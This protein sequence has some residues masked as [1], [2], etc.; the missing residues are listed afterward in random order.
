MCA[1]I[2]A[3]GSPSWLPYCPQGPKGTAFRSKTASS[4]RKDTGFSMCLITVCFQPL[5]NWTDFVSFTPPTP[6][7]SISSCLSVHLLSLHV[8]RWSCGWSDRLIKSSA[9]SSSSS[10]SQGRCSWVSCSP[11]WYCF[12]SFLNHFAAFQRPWHSLGWH[13]NYYLSRSIMKV[14]TSSRWPVT[15]STRLCLTIQ[16]GPSM[17]VYPIFYVFL[18]WSLQYLIC[19]TLCPLVGFQRLVW[20]R[21]LWIQLL[22]MFINMVENG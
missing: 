6:F 15:S 4:Q 22:L 19:C 20:C 10:W 11:L 8:R 21:R 14:L 18:F 2:L 5:Q 16:N 13:S 9:S 1:D 17:T 7:S 12:C 3:V